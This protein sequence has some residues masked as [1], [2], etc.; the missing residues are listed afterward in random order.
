AMLA[1]FITNLL[2]LAGSR[3]REYGADE[4][5]VK[6]GNHPHHLASALYK[7]VYGSA[8]CRKTARGE[9]ELHRVEG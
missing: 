1:Y 4:T 3:I 8:Q 5:S 2:V 7:L 9:E 6:L